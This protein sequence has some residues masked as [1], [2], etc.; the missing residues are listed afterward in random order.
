MYE[1]KK[2]KT[3]TKWGGG[4]EGEVAVQYTWPGVFSSNPGLT[5]PFS[6]YAMETAV[7][8]DYPYSQVKL[9]G[10]YV[11]TLNFVDQGLP[12]W[13]SHLTLMLL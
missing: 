6:H 5:F 9:W 1:D 10:K 13:T 3:R 2:T 8:A 4:W 12:G 11:M 7:M